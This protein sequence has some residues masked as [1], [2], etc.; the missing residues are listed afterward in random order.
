MRTVLTISPHLDDAAFSAGAALARLSARGWRVVVATVFTGNVARPTGFALACQ[1]DKGLQPDADYMALRRG[2]DEAACTALGATPIHLPHLEAPNR[3][4]ED[5]PALFAGVR[6]DDNA[7]A[8]VAADLS[9][10]IRKHQPAL[11]LAPRGVGGHVDHVVVRRALDRLDRP[12]ASY[13]TDWPYAGKPD[14]ADPFAAADE[15]KRAVQVPAAPYLPAKLAACAAYTTQLGYQFG[16]EA[17][18]RE[19]VGAVSAERFLV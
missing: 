16:G 17:G 4:Y 8:A 11:V 19:S 9:S 5:A 6:D 3:G 7:E 10:L 12:S 2:E 13:W 18:M 14:A 15:A 1:L